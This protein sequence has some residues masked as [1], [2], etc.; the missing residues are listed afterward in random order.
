MNEHLDQE[1]LGQSFEVAQY[2]LAVP[3]VLFLYLYLLAVVLSNRHKKKWPYYRTVFWVIGI[4]LALVSVIGPVADKGHTDFRFHML[5]HLFLGMLAP[6]LMALG[7]SMTLFL[8]SLPVRAARKV[9]KLLHCKFFGF[10]QDP[11][12][13]TV[14]NIGGLWLLYTTDLYELMHQHAWI[15]FVVHLHIFVAGYLF[16]ISLIYIDPTSHRKGYLYRTIIFVMALAG[17]K[18][19]SKYIYANPPFG[20]SKEAAEAGG[21]L[22]YY[23]GDAIEVC[24]IT[25]LFFHWYKATKPKTNY[26]QAETT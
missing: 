24:L 3:F 26:L 17:H 10:Y 5:G 13:A 21:M 11:F 4:L 19:L 18:I 2:L 9:T 12:V 14:L 25:L 15:Y 8:R 22:M 1:V 23:G 16:T 20:V 7:A 6:F